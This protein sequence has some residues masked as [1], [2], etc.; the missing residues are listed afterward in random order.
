MLDRYPL[1]ISQL[2]QAKDELAAMKQRAE[3]ISQLMAAGYG[4][5]DPRAIRAGEL[6]A[7]I[8][9]LQWELDRSGGNNAESTTA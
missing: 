6:N 1:T 8:Q 3:E 5:S 2:R 4:A 7:A 9:R